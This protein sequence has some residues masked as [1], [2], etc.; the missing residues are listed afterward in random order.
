MHCCF[1]SSLEQ[2]VHTES[3]SYNEQ[4]CAPSSMKASHVYRMKL[5][6]RAQ[7]SHQSEANV[8]KYGSEVDTFDSPSWTT[9]QSFISYGG[10]CQI[11]SRSQSKQSTNSQNHYGG[12]RCSSVSDALPYQVHGSGADRLGFHFENKS[13]EF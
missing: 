12:K 3:P 9:R 7:I 1:R 13:C 11:S 8:V 6:Y 5:L 2:S 4:T 10:Y